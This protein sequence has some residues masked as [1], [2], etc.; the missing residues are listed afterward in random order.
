MNILVATSLSQGARDNDYHWCV[1]GELVTIDEPCGRDRRT[2]ENGCGC[3]RGFAGLSSHRATTTARI[4]E[5]PGFTVGDYIAALESG[6]AAQG[7]DPADAAEIAL[8][9]LELISGWP[10]GAILERPFDMIGIRCHESDLDEA[11]V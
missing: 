2:P 1:E 6:L 10:T 5:I 8:A 7:W 4:A 11:T 3:S 9:Q